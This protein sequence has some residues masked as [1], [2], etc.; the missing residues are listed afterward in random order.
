MSEKFSE[1]QNDGWNNMLRANEQA[2]GRAGRKQGKK[3][4]P[5]PAVPQRASLLAQNQ[6]SELDE[7][8]TFSECVEE[9]NCPPG[10]SAI[11]GRLGLLVAGQTAMK[12]GGAS[13]AELE[14]IETLIRFVS[15]QL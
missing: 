6:F 8:E 1:K 2:N 11:A 14:A 13:Q 4:A 15:G 7:S 3:K 5:A 10:H 9:G 12:A